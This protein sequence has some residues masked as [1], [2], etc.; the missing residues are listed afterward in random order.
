MTARVIALR[1]CPIVNEDG[2]AGETI[3]PGHLVKGVT[4]ILKHATAGGAAARTFALERDELGMGVD[5]TY[6][7]VNTSVSYASGDT[8]K[9]GSFAP[10]MQ[11][12]ALIGSGQNISADGF[13]ES[14]GNGTLRALASGVRIARA[15][16]SVDNSAGTDDAGINVEV[17]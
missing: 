6:T 11:V 17:Y 13:L 9:V 3:K 16:E 8:V 1:G 2:A 10:G 12:R 4:T 14:A 7:D 15:L 5:T